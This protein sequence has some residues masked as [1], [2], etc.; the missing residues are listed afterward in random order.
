MPT[1]NANSRAVSFGQKVHKHKARSTG[2]PSR[3][4][5]R[6]PGTTCRLAEGRERS[7]ER[8][9]EEEA[10]WIEQGLAPCQAE[11]LV[12]RRG[13]V[14][15]ATEHT[16]VAQRVAQYSTLVP[17]INIALA[18]LCDPSFLN[19]PL[20][21]GSHK[22]STL[23]QH[24]PEQLT[25]SLKEN[26]VQMQ[27]LRVLTNPTIS[28][29][30]K[31]EGSTVWSTLHKEMHTETEE[32]AQMR[33]SFQ[34]V[35]FESKYR[36]VQE[37]GQLWCAT[38]CL[39]TLHFSGTDNLDQL[40]VSVTLPEDVACVHRIEV[41]AT[42]HDQGPCVGEI[43]GKQGCTWAEVGVLDE[44]GNVVARTHAYTNEPHFESW[45]QHSATLDMQESCIMDPYSGSC[46]SDFLL[47]GVQ[48]G[49]LLRSF[50]P[51]WYHHVKRASITVWYSTIHD[52]HAEDR[53]QAL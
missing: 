26:E 52:T 2:R 48:V 1:T 8:N 38:A 46:L 9:L 49:L 22:L 24:L 39:S 6:R 14:V 27:S 17:G 37:S 50:L 21:Q 40:H 28:S 16:I 30:P 23:V 47:P 42:A 43:E 5:S 25:D 19:L 20:E 15:D 31:S 7:R 33:R 3:A 10:F 51:G 36:Q 41:T 4:R 11:N 13:N 53:A 18:A 45:Q 44:T 35:H 29:A 12:R 32:V 34:Q